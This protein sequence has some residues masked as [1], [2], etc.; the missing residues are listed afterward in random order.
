MGEFGSLEAFRTAVKGFEANGMQ[1]DASTRE[2]LRSPDLRNFRTSRRIERPKG[3]PP[4]PEEVRKLLGW[5]EEQ[6]RSVG[7]YPFG[8]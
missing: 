7:A 5:T 8:S 1:I 3:A 4:L 2:V 6:A